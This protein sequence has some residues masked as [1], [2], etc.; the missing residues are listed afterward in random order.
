MD[1]KYSQEELLSN[2]K[3][4]GI[5]SGDT[6]FVRAGLRKINSEGRSTFLNALLEVVGKEGTVLTLSFNE[7]DYWP[8]FNENNVFTVDGPTTAGSFPKQ[9]IN[10]PNGKRSLHPTC[11]YA[12]IGKNAELILKNHDENATS[13]LPIKRLIDLNGK[14]LLTGCLEESPGFTT[15]HYVQEIL[16]LSKKSILKN[17]SGIYYSKDGEKKKFFRKDIG[18]CSL[19]FGAFYQHYINKGYL[20]HGMIGDAHSIIVGAKEAFETEL[21]IMKTQPTYA[22]CR[23]SQCTMC[24]ATWTYNKKEMF[25]FIIFELPRKILKK[26]LKLK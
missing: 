20:K 5:N 14:M 6:V 11:S 9:I 19:G 8:F 1:E 22:L 23:N 18:G 15:V 25:S 26:I 12:A 24:R 7:H 13:Y 4:L 16:G 3:A 21:E 17:L 2:I 10:H